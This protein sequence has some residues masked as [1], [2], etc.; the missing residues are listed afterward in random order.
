MKKVEV[1]A[2]G[3][4]SCS[5]C[6]DS[7]MSKEEVSDEV[8]RM[9]PTGISPQWAVTEDDFASGE[10]NGKECEHDKL[11]KHYLLHC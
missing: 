9:N 6:A 1:Y 2:N 5:V 10:K 4:V 8:N 7:E 3:I 11:R